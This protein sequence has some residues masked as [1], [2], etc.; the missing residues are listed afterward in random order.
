MDLPFGL[1]KLEDSSRNPDH[2]L[3]GVHGFKGLGREWVTP[4][5]EWNNEAT[6]LYFLRWNY[7]ARQSKARELLLTELA[8]LLT[9][10]PADVRLTFVGHSC[11]GVLLTS[12]LE[13]LSYPNSI[14]VHL[15]ASPLAGLGLFTVCKPDL[16]EQLPDNITLTHWQTQQ[17]V[18]KVF[19]YFPKNPQEVDFAPI[20]VIVLP[21]KSDDTIVGHVHSLAWVAKE[22]V[23][24]QPAIYG[25]T[26]LKKSE[27]VQDTVRTETPRL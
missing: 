2:I 8:S 15:V 6:D 12:I 25:S 16:P 20:E 13:Q 14:D 5:L 17:K 19:W 26:Y 11:G 24:R 18:D 9:E 27:T 23:R 3:I 21:R 4:F 10:T 7:F 22:M 1:H